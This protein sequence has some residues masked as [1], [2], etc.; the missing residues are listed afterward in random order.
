[1]LYELLTGH[2][3]YRF[4]TRRPDELARIICEQEPERPST[5]VSRIN[6][7]T[8]VAGDGTTSPTDTVLRGHSPVKLQK[9]LRGDLDNIILKAMRKQPASRYSSVQ[10]FSAD[11]GRHLSGLPVHARNQTIAYHGLAFLRRRI[12]PNWKQILFVVLGVLVLSVAIAGYS[13]Y[14]LRRRVEKPAAYPA[15]RSIAVL[16]FHYAGSGPADNPTLGLGFT[17]SLITS[18]GQTGKLEVR[19][20]SAVQTFISGDVN[21][22]PIGESLG[23]DVVLS[24]RIQR[25]GETTSITAEILSIK[26]G[27]VLWKRLLSGRHNEIVSLQNTIAEEVAQALTL[28]LSEAEHR[29][30]TRSR[31]NNAR[32]YELY[33]RGRYF[34]NKRTPDAYESAIEY[35]N[36]A[37][38]LDPD[39]AEARAGLA[40]AYALLACVVEQFDKRAER[41]KIAKEQALK[42]LEIDETLA[43]PHATL[44]FIG[45]HYDWD[46]A[47]SDREFKRALQ[48]NPS[49]ATAHHWYS[50]LLIRLG[51]SDEAVAEIKQARD[52]DRVSPIMNQDYT[53]ILYFARRYDET[54]EAAHKTLELAPDNAYMRALILSSYL[55]KG[56]QQEY[57]GSLQ[58]QVRLSGRKPADL[59]DLATGFFRLNRKEEGRQVLNELQQRGV[60]PVFDELSEYFVFGD[61]QKIYEMLQREYNYRGAGITMIHRH[62]DFD[63]IRSDPRIQEYIRLTGLSQFQ[64]KN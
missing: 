44:G 31:T 18:L 62:P 42:S 3:P 2:R 28:Q 7:K 23:V 13:N 49:Y 47:T 48:L 26:D 27:K 33:I 38:A 20:L 5:A 10:E 36:Q 63:E 6:N 45:W 60:K 1:M 51:R 19:P 40:D 50:F 34:W 24:G 15:I 46:W 30:L 54:I 22:Q 17:E 11:I 12:T 52:L 57:I 35:F 53:E 43:E 39:Y 41:M 8:T 9:L 55:H 37:I 61:K 32:A 58:E 4:K 25:D 14:L 16:P 64:I 59:Q 29:N 21:P 56:A